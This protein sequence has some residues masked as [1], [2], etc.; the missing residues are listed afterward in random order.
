MALIG[1][2]KSLLPHHPSSR[3][4]L[5]FLTRR[6]VTISSMQE[7]FTQPTAASIEF[8]FKILIV[9]GLLAIIVG[10]GFAFAEKRSQAER[11]D[12]AIAS[13]V[14]YLKSSIDSDGKCAGEFDQAHEQFG[15]RTAVC[16]YALLT[17]NPIA[18]DPAVE[19]S[20]NWL[21]EAELTGTYPVAL[22]T[23]AM[24]AW[25]SGRALPIIKKDVDWLLKAADST[26]GYSSSS[27]KN[28]RGK[29]IDNFHTVFAALAVAAAGQRGIIVSDDYWRAI[30]QHFVASQQDDGGWAYRVR[31]PVM[32]AKTYGSLTAG[33]LTAVSA[34]FEKLHSLKYLSPTGPG[35]Y[36]PIERAL[37]W[38]S[39]NFTISENPKLGYNWYYQWLYL[40]ERAGWASGRK[41]FGGEDWY[42]RGVSALVSTQHAD[43]SWGHGKSIEQTAW[44]LLFLCRGRQPVLL[45]KLSFDG[46]WNRRPRD[47]ANLTRWVGRTFEKPMRWQIVEIDSPISDWHDAQI[48]YI[49]GAGPAE[50]NAA[51]VD[52]LRR[53]VYQGGLIVSEAVG[54]SA[55]FT[56]SM[57][58]LFR[59]LSHDYPL[60]ELPK[61]HPI[62][63]LHFSPD[64]PAS[65][66]GISN[67]IRLLAIHSPQDF[68][69]SLQMGPGREQTAQFELAANIYLYATDSGTHKP[70]AQQGWP[71]LIALDKPV[72]T[73][74]LARLKYDGNFDPE[75][76]ALNRLAGELAQI[77]N[78]KLVVS[79]PL[80]IAQLDAETWPIAAMTGTESFTL[81]EPEL[82]AMRKYLRSGGTLIVDAAGGSAQFADSA[83]E[84]LLNL[85]PQGQQRPVFVE[86]IQFGLGSAAF[87]PIQY[88]RDFATA[89]GP[90]ADR[91]R[92][93]AVYLDD[94]PAIFYSREDITAGLV[95]YPGYRL[96]G[97]TPQTALAIMKKLLILASD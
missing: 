26:G 22:R 1:Q 78:T 96:R 36:E 7:Q 75:P 18:T 41:Y 21:A 74:K 11:L 44:A 17:A 34:C 30:Q 70:W 88:R 19:R 39:S 31:P 47:A 40:L 52:K 66:W 91:L 93:Q 9:L 50:F 37:E 97:Y 6:P 55:A 33:G 29:R 56:L 20:I 86:Q 13:A 67:G 80:E 12:Q 81:T 64:K 43:G 4:E 82:S 48:L 90:A 51:Q 72:R 63:S 15:S 83:E 42:R 95:G 2:L 38:L 14:S 92:L 87:E 62:Y 79:D 58:R 53:F 3:I 10:P 46:N 5:F 35:E 49:S 61:N 8:R 89:L 45:N 32:S 85:L 76:L 73:I 16:L 94:R 23:L 24:S 27:L 60:T 57:Q 68:S 54:N 84:Q 69:R 77:D 65:L 59:Q 25:P 28:R 71:E